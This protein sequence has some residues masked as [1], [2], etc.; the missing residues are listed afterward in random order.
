MLDGQHAGEFA[1]VSHSHS[2]KK[3]CADNYEAMTNVAS[4]IAVPFP[5]TFN[6]APYL[7]ISGIIASGTYAG[8]MAHIPHA[9]P[10]TSNVVVTIQYWNGSSFSNVGNNVD[11]IL[12]YTAIEK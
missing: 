7:S 8:E 2:E 11:V 6:A 1:D 9:T 3:A 12:S 4:Q 10:G 5:V